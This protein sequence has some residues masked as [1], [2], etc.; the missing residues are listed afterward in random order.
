MLPQAGRIAARS[1]VILVAASVFLVIGIAIILAYKITNSASPGWATSFI[2][3]LTVA[4]GLALNLTIGALTIF[5]IV[6]KD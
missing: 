4:F 1:F 5:A 6:R 2:V 3:L